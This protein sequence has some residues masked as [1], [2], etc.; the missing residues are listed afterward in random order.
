[1]TVYRLVDGKPEAVTV[2]IGASDGTRSE[3][4]GSELARATW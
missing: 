1:V 2:R 4:V 3:L